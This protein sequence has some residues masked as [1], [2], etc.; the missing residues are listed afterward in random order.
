MAELK[1]C[2]KCGRKLLFEDSAF[3]YPLCVMSDTGTGK[4]QLRICASD[5]VY[6]DG[7][8]TVCERN[9]CITISTT[10]SLETGGG[11]QCCILK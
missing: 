8:C 1:P 5:W 9:K 6:C 10:I 11:R 4:E 7:K 2:P 3:Y